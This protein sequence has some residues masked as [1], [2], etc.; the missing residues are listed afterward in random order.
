ML[1]KFVLIFSLSSLA[2][3]KD[4]MQND[5]SE[6][7]N[8]I[9]ERQTNLK[10]LQARVL[11]IE[12]QLGKKNHEYLEQG[13]HF[14]HM[15]QR[16]EDLR[17]SLEISSRKLSQEFHQILRLKDD[18]VLGSLDVENQHDLLEQDLI[19]RALKLY[20]KRYRIFTQETERIRL[21]KEDLV[22]KLATLRGKEEKSYR[23]VV[24]LERKKEELQVEVESR[25]KLLAELAQN[26]AAK[27]ESIQEKKKHD[28]AIVYRQGDFILPLYSPGKV[29]VSGKGLHLWSSTQQKIRASGNG[30][31]V[32]IGELSSYGTV[33]VLDHGEQVRT[34]YLGQINPMVK[35]GEKL[36]AGQALASFDFSEGE[37]TVKL[38]FELRK[39][40][41][42]QNIKK[43]MTRPILA[44]R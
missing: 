15:S 28:S 8:Q 16:V 10:N 33:I 36:N 4:Q 42:L 26:L 1:F 6:I 12:A 7:R 44:Q 17:Q 13:E 34:V 11:E 22:A 20:G 9:V 38:Y 43:W 31:V 30:S 23:H 39:R 24:E 35:I 3:A 37:G 25:K 5:L 21:K 27:R 29:S 40:N 18:Y 2:V 19:V 41:R 14:E 32:H